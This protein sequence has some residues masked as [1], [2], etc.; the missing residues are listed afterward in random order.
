MSNAGIKSLSKMSTF[1]RDALAVQ[2]LYVAAK[3]RLAEAVAT[4][5]R[6][7]GELARETDTDRDRLLRLMRVLVHLGLFTEDDDGR[8]ATTPLGETLRADHPKSARGPLLTWAAPFFW[9]PWGELYESLKTGEPAFD[10]IF[11]MPFYEYLAAHP[12]DA[13]PFYGSIEVEE[14]AVLSAIVAAYDFSR[15]ERLVS[16]GAG[17]YGELLRDI[18]L[19]HP[20]VRGVFNDL[21]GV[22]ERADMLRNSPVADRCEFIASDI[23]E[24]V[25]ADAD[26]YL[27]KGTLH[28]WSD[29]ESVKILRSCRR[30]IRP[31]GRLLL[32]EHVL[33]SPDERIGPALALQ[34][35]A[36]VVK[37]RGRLRTAEDFRRMFKESGFSE[38]QIYPTGAGG[39]GRCVVEAIPV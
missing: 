1:W 18:L 20:K 34:H 13:E 32:V 14:P 4:S 21:P 37:S 11:G 38:P 2:V 33:S 36:F 9:R 8:F 15:F 7:I 26:G 19:A 5:A 27:L 10:R 30:A 17:P 6:T 39:E 35:L 12:E 23:F 25:P 16:V 22:V 24:S 3:L 28:D 31:S 29:G